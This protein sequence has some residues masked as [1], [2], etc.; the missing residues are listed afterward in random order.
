MIVM[1]FGIVVKSV[2][3]GVASYGLAA[4]KFTG[5]IMSTISRREL[6]RS[7]PAVALAPRL[8]GQAAAPAAP[9]QPAQS[10]KPTIPLKGLNYFTLAVSDMK[11][12]IDFYQGLFG[13]PIQARQ[14]QNVLMR[15][16]K[17]PQFILLTP[18]GSNPP[19]I[20]PRLGLKVDNF[21][22]DR[23]IGMLEQHGITRAAA[24]DA[25]LTG[26]AMKVRLSRRGPENGGA[27]DGTPE[28]FLGDPDDF[29]LQIQD[30]S[31]AGGAGAMGNVVKVE[32]SP[33]KGLLALSDMSHF[34]INASDGTRTQNFYQETFGTPVRSRQA[35]TPAMG[36]GPGV[37]FLMFIGGGGG[38][39]GARGAARGAAPGAPAGPAPAAPAIPPAGPR[40]S[41]N[42]VSMNMENFKPDEVM[43]T[44]AS[45]GIGERGAGGG[46]T[47]PLKSYISLRMPDR[48]GAE[49]GTPELY[50][51][52]PDG[53]LLQL[54]D[55]KYCGGGGFLGDV[56]LG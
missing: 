36:I 41:V 9:A 6:L 8:F 44:L 53:L 1:A 34:T 26:G 50:F 39:G 11:R 5:G 40:A 48:G 18:A 16:G 7:I 35:T 42:H 31:F 19:S 28:L 20:V 17:G 43:K 54:Q 25:G 24:G 49:G 15:I 51:T 21:N 56:C 23:I 29:V 52:D 13:M 22:P 14:G 32:E 4:S 55:V 47:G 37:H 45:F 46:A 3:N 2:Q 10:G 33:K 38:R 30:T 27:S 12:S